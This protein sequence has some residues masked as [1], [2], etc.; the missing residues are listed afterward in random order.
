METT[1]RQKE[2]INAAFTLISTQGI[3][4]LTIK[5]LGK[6]IGVSEPAIYRH[7]ASK[8]EI[9]S[10]IVDEITAVKN[11]T[12]A[13]SRS[14]DADPRLCLRRFFSHQ[15]SEFEIFPPLSIILS[16]EDLFRTDVGLIT[17]IRG[18]MAETR[19]TITKLIE[20]ARKSGDI[21]KNIDSQTVSLMLLGGFRMLVSTWRLEKEHGHED[22]LTRL[23]EKFLSQT[24]KMLE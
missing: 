18:L 9:L 11:R 22:S 16:P 5:N 12:L 2:I 23:T 10:G 7:F 8:A 15:A 3:Q 17:R 19:N 6:A 24:L 13:F 20:A 14:G 4:D 21:R 1:E